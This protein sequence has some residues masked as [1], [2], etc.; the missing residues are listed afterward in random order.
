MSYLMMMLLIGLVIGLVGV[1]ANPS[2]YF[3][4]LALV[5][6]SGLGCGILIGYGGAF[7]SLVLFLIYLGGM[8]V[9]FAYTAALAADDHPET[10]GS[11]PV[12]SYM[13]LYLVG[14]AVAGLYFYYV[15]YGGF[16]TSA[17]ES[18]EYGSTRRHMD[19][20]GLIY[21]SGG[22]LLVLCGVALT[23]TLV[24]VLELVRGLARGALR[25]V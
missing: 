20:V 19:G 23:L 10:L 14:L 13:V 11:R 15:W 16:G 4:A 2:P 22:V 7:L 21:S 9:V 8:M 12:F 17:D 3:G 5:G 25:A 24:V 18:E 6:V 1:A